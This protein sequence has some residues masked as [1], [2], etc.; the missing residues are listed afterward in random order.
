M[1]T[2]IKAS[3][4][5]TKEEKEF[6]KHLFSITLQG[7]IDSVKYIL[8]NQSVDLSVYDNNNKHYNPI[9]YAAAWSENIELM[10]YLIDKGAS[11]KART[12]SNE[13]ALHR[14]A[15]KGNLDAVKLL[16]EN[17]AELDVIY[18][19]NGGLLPLSC[20]AES[21]NIEVVKYLIEKGAKTRF[22]DE[23]RVATPLRS[24]AYKA[25]YD[26]FLLF[27]QQQPANY[28]WQEALF[29]GLHGG[30]L[31]IVKY[32]V[33][34][35]GANVN[36]K[37]TI[38][39]EYPIQ[40]A[41]DD[42]F[43]WNKN[44]QSVEVVKYL[45]SKGAKLSSINNGDLF[46]WAMQHCSED[47]ME[48]LIQQG[49]KLPSSPSSSPYIDVVDGG[50]TP[51]A[52][53]LDK[54]RFVVAKHLLKATKDHTFR[55]KP[56]VVAFADGLSNSPAI[57]DLL[58][59]EGINKEHYSQALMYAVAS[60]DSTSTVLLLEAGADI[61][62]LN[63]DSSNVLRLI[64]S[65]PIAQL[66][67]EKGAD[68]H[69]AVMLENAWKN[70]PLLQAL[71]EVNVVPPISQDNLNR[72][73]A[74]S[75]EQGDV[76]TLNYLLKRGAEV[77]VLGAENTTPLI[78]NAIQGYAYCNY[79]TY[80]DEN[81][82]VQVLPHVT[83]ILLKAGADP[84]IV[85]NQGK[86]A[87]HYAAGDQY[88]RVGVGPIPMGGRRDREQGAHGDPA[89]PPSQYHDAI[90]RLLIENGANPDIQDKEGNTP[91]ILAAQHRTDEVLKM[92]LNAGADITLKN[93]KGEDAFHYL[94]DL[95][96]FRVMKD[97]G[98]WNHVSQANLNT[99]FEKFFTDYRSRSRYDVDELKTLLDYGANPNTVLYGGSMTAL[100][101]A[102][103]RIYGD[104]KYEI[105]RVLIAGGFDIYSE[106]R[107]GHPLFMEMIRMGKTGDGYS[108]DKTPYHLIFL[109]DNGF[110][111]NYKTKSQC[112]ALAV[113]LCEGRKEI[114]D[115][116]I[117]NGAKRDRDSEWWYLVGQGNSPSND[118]IRMLQQ[119]VEAGVD[120]NQQAPDIVSKYYPILQRPGMTA[121]MMYSVFSSEEGVNA[122]I[123]MGADVNLKAADGITALDIAKDYYN[124]NIVE[125]LLRAGAE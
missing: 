34:K 90:A 57:I 30:N 17:G 28:N 19:A 103:E 3:D 37:S 101:Y 44:A 55:G 78:K 92:L 25:H 59:K 24:A 67:I 106:A 100:Q 91:L 35:R 118:R 117:S 79:G 65:Y 85:D 54:S 80:V 13:T 95:A 93:N 16:V 62:T 110:D 124:P 66:L 72:M 104:D 75:A 27:A 86:T 89:M 119:L 33:E 23:E 6:Y 8:E 47:M 10:Q 63:P 49:M 99:A 83:E 38:W 96:S 41:A 1:T 113:A 43:T 88:C 42:R 112:T 70:P 5:P 21:G 11:A 31:D 12:S 114:A 51:L 61:N 64:T 26:I 123:K 40:K 7:D 4:I 125:I 108:E 56:L 22:S 36:K 77:D 111:I 18:N 121:L 84:N 50:W 107:N 20:A 120:V 76:R 71:D 45:I 68:V 15:W 39:K 98:L 29:Y 9:I 115:F 32:I 97:A 122:L 74:N 46:N 102:F 53:A 94:D 82:K 69:N 105:A 116:L 58:I 87:L 73:L 48:Y 52:T 14:A 2:S 81:S 60:N 109:L